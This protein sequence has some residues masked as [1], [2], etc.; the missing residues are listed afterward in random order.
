MQRNKEKKEA[1]D[2][3]Q[4]QTWSWACAP[5]QAARPRSWGPGLETRHLLQVV[6]KGL[7]L[8][9]TQKG[10]SSAHIRTL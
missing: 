8:K 1:A 9:T 3:C 5:A 4:P 6:T 7:G 2:S 10:R